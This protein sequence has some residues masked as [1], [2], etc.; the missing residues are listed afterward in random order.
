L[1][2]R[3]STVKVI[4]KETNYEMCPFRS[5]GCPKIYFTIKV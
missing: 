2:L 5:K 1:D 3:F 4:E